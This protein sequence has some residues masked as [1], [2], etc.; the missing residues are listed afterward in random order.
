M[1]AQL[2]ELASSTRSFEIGMKWK[3]IATRASVRDCCAIL[4][5]LHHVWVRECN[6]HHAKNSDKEDLA[7]AYSVDD[8]Q[9]DNAEDEVGGAD[10]DGDGR[11]IIEPDEGE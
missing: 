6:T 10:D 7:S 9:I 4:L 3:A 8:D 5:A 2:T 11:G 1:P